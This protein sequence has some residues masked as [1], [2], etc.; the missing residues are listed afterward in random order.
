[1]R[2]Y[3]VIHVDKNVGAR[4]IAAEPIDRT[5]GLEKIKDLIDRDASTISDSEP[6]GEFVSLEAEI[7]TSKIKLALNVYGGDS[8]N[9]L[10]HEF[11]NWRYLLEPIGPTPIPRVT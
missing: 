9:V 8:D 5:G 6:R 3:R 4:V 10:E 2:T 1:M 11:R 7:D